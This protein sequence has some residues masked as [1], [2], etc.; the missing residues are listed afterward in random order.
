MELFYFYNS[1]SIKWK[2]VSVAYVLWRK[3]EASFLILCLYSLLLGSSSSPSRS[4]WCQAVPA[5]FFSVVIA[6]RRLLRFQQSQWANWTWA[7]NVKALY[8]P[9]CIAVNTH[10]CRVSI[11]GRVTLDKINPTLTAFVPQTCSC[12]V[13]TRSCI[14]F[15]TCI[16]LEVYCWG[17][18]KT[19]FFMAEV[20]YTG[21]TCKLL[22]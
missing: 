21:K 19:L 9:L 6:R 18:M 3:G 16:N 17:G 20:L 2:Y 12:V 14:H 10:Y 22:C 15:V 4:V 13:D 11:G 5:A 7:V 8:K 1:T